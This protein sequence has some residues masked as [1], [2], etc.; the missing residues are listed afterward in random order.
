MASMV[1][2]PGSS[3]HEEVDSFST[4]HEAFV[5]NDDEDNDVGNCLTTNNT[6][7][8]D[9]GNLRISQSS[10]DPGEDAVK[11]ILGALKLRPLLMVERVF[12]SKALCAGTTS[13]SDARFSP[14]AVEML[15]HISRDY[16]SGGEE[17]EEATD[18]SALVEQLEWADEWMPST[19]KQVDTK[20][21]K[22]AQV[23]MPLVPRVTKPDQTRRLL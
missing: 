11:P 21:P 10:G 1:A 5:C 3:D 4:A 20:P 18:T 7:L 17:V 2:D 15:S 19:R 6:A 23:G 14:A 8:V 13:H 22:K 16:S 12:G 9:L